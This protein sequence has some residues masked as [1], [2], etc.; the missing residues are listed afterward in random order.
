MGGLV[1]CGMG[2]GFQLRM[3]LA[4][5]LIGLG[6]RLEAAV[7]MEPKIHRIYSVK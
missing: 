2:E 7:G 5:G 3:G 1:G 4:A 6:V